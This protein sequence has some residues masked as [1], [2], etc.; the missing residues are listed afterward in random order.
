MNC[1]AYFMLHSTQ[2]Q[3]ICAA[4]FLGNRVPDC[5]VNYKCETDD[6]DNELN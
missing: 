1:Q 5:S 2:Q 4:S 6:V 3:Q